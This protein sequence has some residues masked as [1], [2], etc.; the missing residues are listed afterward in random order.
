M[1]NHHEPFQALEPVDWNQIP[2]DNLSEFLR[3]IFDRALLAV[4]S[5]PSSAST[6][7]EPV[8]RLRAKTESAVNS[9]AGQRLQ[10][11]EA[12]A[13]A[14]EA[15]QRLQKDWKEVKLNPRDNP[16]A[17]SV[18]KLAAKD[19]KGSWFARQ[20]IHEELSFDDWRLGLKKEFA[21]T[22][23]VQGA[24][25]SGSIRGIGADKVVE[26]IAVDAAGELDSE[27]SDS[28]VVR[29]YLLSNTTV[30]FFSYLHNSQVRHLHEILL[31]F[32]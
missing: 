20:S 29:R 23:K 18:F 30:Q 4:D 5:V 22:M 3:S 1:S 8:G 12:S 26:H 14:M 7:S 17:I 19:G 11:L 32:F 24:P 25:G 6:A 10:T 31:R 15:A 16:R 2:K 9:A 27:Y 21:E 28:H 13:K